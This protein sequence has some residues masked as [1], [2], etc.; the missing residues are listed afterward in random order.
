M[1]ENI[2]TGGGVDNTHY[3]CLQGLVTKDSQ[4]KGG[5]YVRGKCA[6]KAR[7][8]SDDLRA[9][10]D[11]TRGL[12]FWGRQ[13]KGRRK[14]AGRNRKVRIKGEKCVSTEMGGG[15]GNFGKS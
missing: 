9:D 14:V 15:G 10:K 11:R 2:I 6:G 8:S 5:E 12:S 3:Q 1:L 7:R 13:R 4:P